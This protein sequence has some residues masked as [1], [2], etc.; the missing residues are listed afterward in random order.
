MCH[1]GR[2]LM[3]AAHLTSKGKDKYWKGQIQSAKIAS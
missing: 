1:L 2:T 3:V